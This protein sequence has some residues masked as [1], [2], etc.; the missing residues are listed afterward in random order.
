M[1]LFVMTRL[2]DEKNMEF[3]VEAALHILRKN[4][5]VKLMIAGTGI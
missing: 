4:N 2:T 5:A 1:L 3:L